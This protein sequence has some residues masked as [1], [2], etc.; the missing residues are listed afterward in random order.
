MADFTQVRA[1]L[2]QDP[3][4][5]RLEPAAKL[6]WL[7]LLTTPT[8]NTAGL[9]HMSTGRL[10]F[11]TSLDH[12][13]VVRAI[14]E[15]KELGWISY[16]DQTGVVWIRNFIGRQPFSET[17]KCKIVKDLN[18]VGMGHPLVKECLAHYASL[19]DTPSIPP[20]YPIDTPSMGSARRNGDGTGTEQEQERT[21]GGGEPVENP[22]T[23]ALVVLRAI[24]GYPFDEKADGERLTQ[25]AEAY[26]K[27]D[28]VTELHKWRDWLAD[29][30]PKKKRNWRLSLRNWVEQAEKIR[31]R[32]HPA[33]VAP[34]PEFNPGFE[35]V[36]REEAAAQAARAAAEI[37]RL[38]EAKS[39]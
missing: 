3:E 6:I 4:F 15:L 23:P 22:L 14:T 21:S 34:A 25:L 5:E 1:D 32:D 27:L 12:E 20:E 31:A 24:P 2:W 38:A 7:N 13:S 29:Q 18:G 35:P 17:I 11:E 26:P 33:P 37:R 9:Y 36:D 8:R 10:A 28:L 39:L 30:P 19:I 16:H